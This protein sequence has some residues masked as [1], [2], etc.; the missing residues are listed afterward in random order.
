M[1]MASDAKVGNLD[2]VRTAIEQMRPPSL[3]SQRQPRPFTHW[4]MIVVWPNR[5]QDAADSFRRNNVRAY[6]PNYEKLTPTRRSKNGLR[7]RGLTLTGIIPGYVFSPAGVGVEDFTTLIERIVGIINVVRTYSGAPLFLAESDIQI[8]RRIEAGLNTPVPDKS[9]HNFKTGE[10]V[11]FIDDLTGRWG[12][13]KIVRLARD[14]RISVEVDLMGR[15]VAV[16]VFP[17]Q[18]ER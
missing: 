2:Q 6:W 4:Y 17:Q 15:K 3:E 8:I 18:I 13:G 12:P 14:G 5:E 7:Q 1:V 11:R 10:K 16:I 9:V